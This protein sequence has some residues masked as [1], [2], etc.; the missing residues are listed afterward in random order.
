MCMYMGQYTHI[1]VLPLSHEGASEQ[2]IPQQQQEHS[3]PR[4]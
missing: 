3:A 2:M 4:S 1:N